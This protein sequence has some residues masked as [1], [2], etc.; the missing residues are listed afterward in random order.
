MFL[1]LIQ[2]LKSMRKNVID[3]MRVYENAQSVV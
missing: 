2:T 3:Q 1:I